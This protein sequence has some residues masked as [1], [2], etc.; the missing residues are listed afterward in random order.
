MIESFNTSTGKVPPATARKEYN[1]KTA[2]GSLKCIPQN[3]LTIV[4]RDIFRLHKLEL[5]PLNDELDV[6][7]DEGTSDD[8]NID[9]DDD[10]HKEVGSE[11]EEDDTDEDEDG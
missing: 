10:V 9:S 3:E 6:T 2:R 4:H 1:E 8:E 5:L 11:D 7:E